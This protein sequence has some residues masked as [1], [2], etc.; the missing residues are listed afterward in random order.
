MSVD[1]IGFVPLDR[2]RDLVRI[3]PAGE[4]SVCGR[5]LAEDFA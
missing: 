4:Q 5:D 2:A 1:H 3:E